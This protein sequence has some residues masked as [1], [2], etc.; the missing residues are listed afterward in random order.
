MNESKHT[1]GPWTVHDASLGGTGYVVHEIC[2]SDERTIATLETDCKDDERDDWSPVAIAANA[3]L[4]ASAPDL[5]EALGKIAQA[6]ERNAPHLSN[7]AHRS[8]ME[9]FGRK[10]RAAIAKATA[11]N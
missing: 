9:W 4:M 8:T 10:A 2:S 3:Q 1:P 7:P 5:L 11:T 6:A